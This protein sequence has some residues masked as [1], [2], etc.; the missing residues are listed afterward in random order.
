[1]GS[2]KPTGKARNLISVQFQNVRPS[3]LYDSPSRVTKLVDL[4]R[5]AGVSASL[6]VGGLSQQVQ[7]PQRIPVAALELLRTDG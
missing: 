1:M 2:L 7:G 5:W 3:R 6:D 4:R